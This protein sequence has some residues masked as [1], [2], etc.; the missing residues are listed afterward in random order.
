MCIIRESEVF[1][2]VIDCFYLE[3]I[4]FIGENNPENNSFPCTYLHSQQV[5]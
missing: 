4:N 5:L 1:S 3:F 2:L